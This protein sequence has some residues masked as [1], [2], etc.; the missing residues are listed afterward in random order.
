M[1]FATLFDYSTHC[2]V[3]CARL[4]AGAAVHILQICFK[5]ISTVP[6]HLSI[7]MLYRFIPS[8]HPYP[9][10]P[11]SPKC[12]SKAHLQPKTLRPHHWRAHQSP[13]AP[14]ARVNYIQGGDADVPCTARLCSLHHHHT[15]RRHSHC[16][17]DMPHRC[18]LRS[19]STERLDV[20]TCRRSTVGG[21]VFPVA[22]AKVWNG[23][24][25]DVTSASSLAVFKNRLKTDYLFRRCYE[26]VW[27]WMT[28][29]F[30][31]ISSPPVQWSSKYC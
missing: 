2:I 9:A 29:P 26:T 15:W 27:L 10:S 4:P 3:C 5:P 14:R 22:G 8:A 7:N 23:L 28:L 11:D 30:P 12:R 13:L 21:R 1:K 25:S 20:P 6:S 24:A 16:V 19:A 31:I 17:A 18:R